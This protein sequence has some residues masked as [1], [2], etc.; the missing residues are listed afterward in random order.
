MY[1]LKK[2]A[3]TI[4]VLIG[5]ATC[6]FLLLRMLP[7]D[8]AEALAGPQAALE[9]VETVRKSLDLDKP[10][11]RLAAALSHPLPTDAFPPKQ[12]QG[13]PRLMWEGPGLPLTEVPA[14]AYSHVGQD[15]VRQ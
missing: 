11:A 7:G 8:P 3:L 2:L 14:A 1:I 15:A 6:S 9:D 10:A 13:V 5:A 12:Y 4:L